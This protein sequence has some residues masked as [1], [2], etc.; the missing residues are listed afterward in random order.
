[1]SLDPYLSESEGAPFVD[2]G[3]LQADL[4]AHSHRVTRWDASVGRLSVLSKMIRVVAMM[5]ESAW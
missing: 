2:V 1:M 5:K 4:Y 3:A